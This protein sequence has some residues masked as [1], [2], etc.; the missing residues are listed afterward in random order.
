MGIIPVT[1]PSIQKYLN[2]SKGD[3]LEILKKNIIKAAEDWSL[4]NIGSLPSSEG[5]Q[6]EV[7]LN[8]LQ[9]SGHLPTDLKNSAT[10]K[11]LSST[12]TYVTIKKINNGFEYI[13]TLI[14]ES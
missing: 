14:E 10:G 5:D 6:Y 7:Y 11:T 12:E 13:V 2:N 9:E 8:E 4:E 3:T 1:V